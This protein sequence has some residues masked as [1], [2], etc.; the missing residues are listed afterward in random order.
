ATI[1][2]AAAIANFA[3][4]ETR[5]SPG[6]LYHGFDNAEIFPNQ[7]R[8]NGAVYPVSDTPG[9]GVDVDEALVKQQSFKFWEAPHLRRNDGSVTNW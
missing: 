6:E 3:W 8:L 7:P 1:H 2:F 5:A 4:L 9:L